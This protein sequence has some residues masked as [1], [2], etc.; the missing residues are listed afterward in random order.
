MEYGALGN[1]HF[2]FYDTRNAEAITSIG[3]VAIK[4]IGNKLNE[5][6]NNILGTDNIDFVIATDTD[7]CYLNFG[8]IVDKFFSGKSNEDITNLL[9]RIA[10]ERVQPFIDKSYHELS[11]YLNSFNMEWFMKREAIASTA[12]FVQK[13]RYFMHILD[14]EG[15]RMKEPKLKIAGL[16]AVR[17]S[18][19]EICRDALKKT[20]KTILESEEEDVQNVVSNFRQDFNSAHILDICMPRSVSDIEKWLDSSGNMKKGTPIGVRAA[21]IFNQAMLEI[22]DTYETIKSGD[23]LKFCYLK[24]PNKFK[25]NVIA[26][27]NILPDRLGLTDSIVDKN[28]QFEKTYLAPVNN[29]LEVIGWSAEKKNTLSSFFG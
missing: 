21:V 23:K 10:K 17:S 5:F 2:L 7:S 29:I 8:P 4:F 18:T 22:D 6:M 24:K 16:E 28:L 9:D 15:V 11:D 25:T 1:Q 19:P 3:Q 14:D 26:L 27:P 12:V 20:M 13:K